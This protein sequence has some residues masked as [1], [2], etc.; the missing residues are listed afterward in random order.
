MAGFLDMLRTAGLQPPVTYRIPEDYPD[1]HTLAWHVQPILPFVQWVYARISAGHRLTRGGYFEGYPFMH[2]IRVVADDP[3]TFLAPSYVGEDITANLHV[4]NAV[5]YE[6]TGI[7]DAS[8][9]TSFYFGTSLGS[10]K[11][12]EELATVSVRRG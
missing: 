8:S 10:K 2:K 1:V 3:V 7:R 9:V 12:S 11:K 4:G 6:R 5:I